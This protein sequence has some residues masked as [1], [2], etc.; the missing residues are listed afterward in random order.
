MKRTE[1]GFDVVGDGFGECRWVSAVDEV[2]PFL[3]PVVVGEMG[4]DVGVC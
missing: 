3:G 2:L 1:D 4:F